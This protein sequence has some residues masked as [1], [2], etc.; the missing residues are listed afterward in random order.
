MVILSYA[1]K[2][3]CEGISLCHLMLVVCF[4]YSGPGL[5]A[6]FYF[7]QVEVN[8]CHSNRDINCAFP[9]R[10][11]CLGSYFIITKGVYLMLLFPEV[12]THA[13]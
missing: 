9:D 3:G 7:G 6:E 4:P 8:I 13:R 2:G 10:L 11:A 12:E 5:G 1:C